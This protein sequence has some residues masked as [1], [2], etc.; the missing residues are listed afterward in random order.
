MGIDGSII[1]NEPFSYLLSDL[2]FD[3]S[4]LVCGSCAVEDE[5]F[6]EVAN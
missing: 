3:V 1:L 6:E 2:S 4:F 5:A